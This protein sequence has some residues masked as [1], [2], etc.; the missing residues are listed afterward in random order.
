MV[1]WTAQK[2]S[3]AAGLTALGGLLSEPVDEG[4]SSRRKAATEAWNRAVA[5]L[6][7]A[8]D[9]GELRADADPEVLASMITGPVVATALARGPKRIDEA[10]ITSLVTSVLEG[11]A[12]AASRR[13]R[14]V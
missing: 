1:R 5:R 13:R 3:S 8:R 4:S 14:N 10:W 6:Q 7:E 9:A 11:S 12:P 2:Y